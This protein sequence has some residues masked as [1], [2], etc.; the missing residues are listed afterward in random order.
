MAA[1]PRRALPRSA[2]LNRLSLTQTA[3]LAKRVRERAALLPSDVLLGV[4]RF[5]KL[6]ARVL[7]E[8]LLAR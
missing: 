2:P 5:H 3:I 4:W 8:E 6:T 1:R 7:G